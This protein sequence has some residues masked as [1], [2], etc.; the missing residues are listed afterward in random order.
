MQVRRSDRG[1]FPAC[2]LQAY[3][4]YEQLLATDRLAA[5]RQRVEMA[6]PRRGASL[7]WLVGL[8][9]LGAAAAALAL[10]L[11]REVGLWGG[12]VAGLDIT[13][14]DLEFFLD[15]ELR[16][17]EVEVLDPEEG[18]LGSREFWGNFVAPS[19]PFVM[20]RGL[21]VAGWVR[22][23]DGPGTWRHFAEEL[24][25]AHGAHELPVQIY[26]PGLVRVPADSAEVLQPA[27]VSMPLRAT[28][29]RVRR[30]G[31]DAP[32]C[33]AVEGAELAEGSPLLDA[34]RSLEPPFAS[35]L[36]PE[37][38]ALW[39]TPPGHRGELRYEGAE[40]LLV[41]LRGSASVTLLDPLQLP[42]LYRTTRAER[43]L[44]PPTSPGG[45]PGSAD[46]A[47][48]TG[49]S[50]ENLSPVRLDDVDLSSH[51]VA[52]A[53]EPIEARLEEGDV[54]YVPALWWS[55]RTALPGTTD[56]EDEGEEDGRSREPNVAVE[57]RY[58]TH[59]TPM[60]KVAAALREQMA[61]D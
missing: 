52:E 32:V 55:Q 26:R 2:P 43:R 61:L 4:R 1:R 22:D 23:G 31:S 40:S 56:E 10:L 48:P 46:D 28:L 60:L 3:V 11:I 47:A 44:T 42:F 7:D 24:G 51:P 33:Y 57:Y 15:E 39:L 19:R 53:A 13:D 38:A 14:D 12:G 9:L 41:Q 59:S 37:A 5:R 36:Q 30:G 58:K 54:L 35:L 49:E 50:I 8:A 17:P 27:Q 21:Q 18:S 29:A 45:P 6:Q 20:R 25:E 34:A 16:T